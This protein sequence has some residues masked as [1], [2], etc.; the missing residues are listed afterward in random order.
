MNDRYS[1]G[2]E[3]RTGVAAHEPLPGDVEVSHVA[4]TMEAAISAGG[5]TYLGDSIHDF[6]R[7]R[8]SWWMRD[9]D[10]WFRVTRPDLAVGLDLMAE[11]IRVAPVVAVLSLAPA[12]T[13]SS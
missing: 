6:A 10:V 4:E 8:S 12:P 9:C 3:I 5:A 2:A 11:N 13:S 7:F 1:A